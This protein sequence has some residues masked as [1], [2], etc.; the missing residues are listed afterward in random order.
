MRIYLIGFMGSGKSYLGKLWAAQNN[1]SFYD[2]DEI[3]EETACNLINEIF[4]KKGENYFRKIEAE[5]LRKT[6]NTENCIIACGG[7]TA[8]FYDNI[9]W[10]NENGITVFLNP[11]TDILIKNLLPQKEQRPLLQS[12]REDALQ[13]FIEDKLKERLPFYKASKI[14][15]EN[16][17][18]HAKGFKEILKN[19]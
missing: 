3:I 7:G 2:L 8:C 16:E 12:I 5:I 9:K 13:S 19:I 15:I 11:S 14:T 1:L 10:M 18:L 17:Y 6:I 4:D